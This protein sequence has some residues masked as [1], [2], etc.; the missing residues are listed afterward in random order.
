MRRNDGP[1]SLLRFRNTIRGSRQPLPALSAARA[2][3]DPTAF[4]DAAAWLHRTPFRGHKLP[5]VYC[6]S[7]YGSL[8]SP[9]TL[10]LL[11]LGPELTW[12]VEVLLRYREHLTDFVSLAEKCAA[13]ILNSDY[14]AAIDTLDQ[15]DNR[16]GFSLWAMKLRIALVQQHE[17]FEAQKG[18][19]QAIR[20]ATREDGVVQYIAHYVSFRNEAIVTPS[21]FYMEYS[22]HLAAMQVPRLIRHYVKYHILNTLEPNEQTCAEILNYEQ[23]SSLVDYFEAVV[24]VA[25]V[26]YRHIGAPFDPRL[27]K[28][29]RD[30]AEGIQDGRL[31]G[32]AFALA[33][34]PRILRR[35]PA[36][37]TGATRL[38]LSGEYT[39]AARS[40]EHELASTAPSV[41]TIELLARACALTGDIP[42]VAGL[43][44]ELVV[45]LSSI[46]IKD[47]NASERL[48]ALR[49]LALNFHPLTWADSL[50]SVCVTETSS[51]PNRESL[52][53]ST[54]SLTQPTTLYP[55]QKHHFSGE[56]DAAFH[57]ACVLAYPNDLAAEYGAFVAGLAESAPLVTFEQAVLAEAD[58]SL[59]RGDYAAAIQAAE[60]LANSCPYYWLKVTR[61][62]AYALVASDALLET[63]SFIA[64]AYLKNARTYY[65]LPIKEV[66]TRIF[67]STQVSDAAKADP[68]LCILCDIYSRHMGKEFDAQ[69]R[70]GFEDFLL[71]QGRSRPSELAS[72][73]KQFDLSKIVY[74]LRYICVPHVIDVSPVYESSTDLAGER[75][76]VCNLLSDID[77]SGKEEYRAEIRDILIRQRAQSGI[78]QI[79]QSKIFVDEEAIRR[80]AQLKWKES[81]ERYRAFGGYNPAEAAEVE[82]ALLKAGAGDRSAFFNLEVEE[83]EKN[84][85]LARL[86]LDIRDEYVAGPDHGL[87]GYLSVRIRHGTFA[88][89]LRTPLE[90]QKL[91]T[92][93]DKATGEYRA[94]SHWLPRLLITEAVVQDVDGAMAAFSRQFDEFV[95]EMLSS[96]I[97][98]RTTELTIGLFDFRIIRAH[99]RLVGSYLAR[100]T[101]FDEFLEVVFSLLRQLLNENVAVVRGRFG[102]VAVARVDQLLNSLEERVAILVGHETPEFSLAVVNAKAE[103][104]QTL[105]R[106]ADWFR[107]PKSTSY[108]AFNAGEAVQIAV[109]LI[110]QIYGKTD[111]APVI[112]SLSGLRLRGVALPSFV[113]I[114]MILFENALKHSGLSGQPEMTVFLNDTGDTLQMV[115]VN[116]VAPIATSERDTANLDQI[117]AALRMGEYRQAVRKEGG[118][119]FQKVHKIITHD[120]GT[121][122]ALAFD[123]RGSNEF[124][125]ELSIKIERLIVNEATADRG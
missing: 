5:L 110:R 63:M 103:L 85:I 94:N 84:S 8:H 72:I 61:I 60:K 87:D 104:H 95:H 113:D 91:I 41:E 68:S 34:D 102:G 70:F 69:I 45:G 21:G 3:L 33:P 7:S 28:L 4:R 38:F 111:F 27:Q 58:R 23:S 53:V 90:R 118:T 112:H 46:I 98:V 93:R 40:A 17:G 97:Q 32:I 47:E 116:T 105:S 80:V 96:W 20:A 12:A 99:A 31:T 66:I 71:A 59:Q 44:G 106:I 100:D 29:V 57:E 9:S 35:L 2:A 39:A 48:A 83:N 51:Y 86:L 16:L 49:K 82:E 121:R 55:C 119:G 78:R 65:T 107:P 88:A 6:P 52:P 64:S 50:R 26:V 18:L 14:S 76:A 25:R 73:I 24:A 75:I 77:P 54:A 124:V 67:E 13:L 79:E 30:F 15:I 56:T 92:Q 37:S 114:F 22:R 74:F 125:V 43:A 108:P 81:Y 36:P 1:Q 19:T 62:K 89:Q 120:L 123:Y 11:P 109:E 117:R 115:V 101:T 10:R 122:G 42:R